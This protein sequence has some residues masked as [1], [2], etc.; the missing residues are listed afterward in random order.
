MA[1][2]LEDLTP[3]YGTVERNASGQ[4]LEEFLEAYNPNKYQNPSVTVDTIVIR[5]PREPRTVETG[6]ELLLIRRGNHPSIGKWAL[7]GGFVNLREDTIDAAK[8]ELQEETGLTGLPVEQLRAWGEYER[9][10]RT[11]IVT[12][13]Y[14]ALIE[15]GR[16]VKA[17][18]DASDAAFFD[19]EFRLE[20]TEVCSGRRTDRYVLRLARSDGAEKLSA[21]VEVSENTEGL[22][23]EQRF[24]V[25]REDGLA[26]DHPAIIV[27]ALLHLQDRIREM[28]IE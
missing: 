28:R 16:K 20:N 14:L 2:F 3:F 8:R 9:D 21:E 11:R 27:Q 1:S 12:V 25:V 18:D 17:G 22:L 26:A 6:L 23:R 15:E 4:T 10:P 13:A 19:V 5:H 7:P 24:R